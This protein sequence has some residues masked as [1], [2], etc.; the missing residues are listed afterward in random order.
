[1]ATSLDALSA[2]SAPAAAVSSKASEAPPV[3]KTMF[4]KLLVAQIQNQNPLKP[5]D[6]IEYLS[7]LAALSSVE[8]LAGIREDLVEIQRLLAAGG[9][10]AAP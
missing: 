1:M 5:V 4:L 3:D 6:G 8:Q 10:A 9:V 7:Q 2:V